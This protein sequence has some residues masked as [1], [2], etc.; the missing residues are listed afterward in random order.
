MGYLCLNGCLI[1]LKKKVGCLTKDCFCFFDDDRE[2]RTAAGQ[3]LRTPPLSSPGGPLHWVIIHARLLLA[4]VPEHVSKKKLLSYLIANVR[5]MQNFTAAIQTWKGLEA[6]G[7]LP[8]GIESLKVEDL[9]GFVSILL[10]EYPRAIKSVVTFV[11]DGWKELSKEE[12]LDEKTVI[13]EFI[14]ALCGLANGGWES[15]LELRSDPHCLPG[16]KSDG[17]GD[18]NESDSE[19][20]TPVDSGDITPSESDNSKAK[21]KDSGDKS[22]DKKV[23]R[24]EARN[25][26]ISREKLDGSK[27]KRRRASS[28]DD[29]GNSD[30]DS[31]HENAKNDASCLPEKGAVKPEDSKDDKTN[32]S[33]EKR[34]NNSTN[35]SEEDSDENKAHYLPGKG[36]VKQKRTDGKQTSSSKAERR[37]NPEE[38]SE[39]EDVKNNAS[40]LPEKGAVKPDDPDEVSHDNSEDESEERVR[41]N[42]RFLPGR[43]TYKHSNSS[44]SSVGRVPDDEN[45]ESSKE[46][47]KN[48]DSSGTS[49]GRAPDEDDEE[50]LKG[51]NEY[52]NS[53]GASGRRS[54]GD[55]NEESSEE[56]LGSSAPDSST[57]VSSSRE[58]GSK[59][60]DSRQGS[61]RTLPSWK[62]SKNLEP[63]KPHDES[64][65]SPDVAG[66]H[67]TG[68]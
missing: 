49:G 25:S 28:K 34:H 15:G 54:P 21:V 35:D 14:K 33:R 23:S 29:G 6:F 26:P 50:S 9:E 61:S 36:N 31:K 65:E 46:D 52:S 63:P 5:E 62:S 58:G 3:W 59:S 27:E 45:D 1:S 8:K 30:E 60:N 43:D 67:G 22:R 57:Q 12:L 39:D 53:S 41:T 24:G 38:D 13:L 68:I 17:S 20:S 56:D 7:R 40:C 19:G 37:D 11:R 2:C 42:P 16:K 4:W 64:A 48:S 51:D 32:S 18:E 44:D 66:M 47:H 10:L 55:E